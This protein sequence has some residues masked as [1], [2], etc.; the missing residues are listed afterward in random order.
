MIVHYANSLMHLT[1]KRFD[2]L[3]AAVSFGQ[4][5]AIL[6]LVAKFVVR[7]QVALT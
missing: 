4:L 7:H 5:S 2:G 1:P 6:L 3:S